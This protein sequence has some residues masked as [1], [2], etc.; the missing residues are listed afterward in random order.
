MKKRNKFAVILFF[1]IWCAQSVVFA[2]GFV[3]LNQGA[4]A[5]AMANAFT[6]RASDPSAVWYNPAGLTQLDGF[7]IY[8]GG[9]LDMIGANKY[10]SIY[11]D[12]VLT[13]DRITNLLPSIYLSY[14]LS[15]RIGL[16]LGINSPLN[17]EIDW[18]QTAEME[19]VVYVLN[20]LEI[21]SLA[22]FP[23]V[24]VKLSENFSL[25]AG[26][27][28]NFYKTNLRYHYRYSTQS[29]VAM[30][31]NGQ[32]RD[33]PDTVI[34]LSD[35]KTS[36]IGFFAGLQFKPTSIVTIGAAYRR[37]A[38]LAFD[39]GTVNAWEPEI[40]NVYARAKLAEIFPDSPEQSAELSF[41]TVDQI[42]AGIAL[43]I[44]ASFDL[45]FDLTWVLWSQ[46][47]NF[48]IDYALETMYRIP[49]WSAMFD[50]ESSTHFR[51]TISA[52]IGGEYKLTPALDLRL[53]AFYHGSPVVIPY[54][55]PAFPLA[56]KAGFSAGFGYRV[57]RF[58]V[59]VA[60]VYN[61]LS[62]LEADNSLFSRWGDTSQ[63]YLS[64]K[65]NNLMINAGIRF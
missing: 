10:Y 26:I 9:L 34:D 38:P 48:D 39:S 61:S 1:G 62:E 31:T 19:H 36:S 11:R 2:N 42:S 52:Q 13:A 29:M 30:L 4:R 33:C 45:E 16:G 41:T 6:A 47:E 56:A 18:P 12:D 20:R 40:D 59:D 14:R 49:F 53:G 64:R 21:S 3:V 17:F 55:S 60:Y 44:G 32:V 65:D 27:N 28:L 5:A 51:N 25:G 35:F 58:N 15:D 8:G 23:A 43:D 54:L 63:K 22:F 50:I 46:M 24:A 7:Q 37:G 57:G